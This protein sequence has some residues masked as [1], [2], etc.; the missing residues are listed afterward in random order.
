MA[1]A[2]ANESMTVNRYLIFSRLAFQEGLSEAGEAFAALAEQEKRHAEVLFG[3]FEG[4]AVEL[5]LT[6]PAIPAGPTR[7][8]IENS[9]AGERAAWSA[10]YPGFAATAREEGY[11]A[12]A[13][14]F[15][16]FARD[17]KAHEERFKRLLQ[18]LS[19][20]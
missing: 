17:E 3:F 13:E 16:A 5:Q 8:N 12:V 7:Q 20:R 10:R 19:D 14:A 6:L 2:F 18:G 15:E 9:L 4:G 11:P 1:F